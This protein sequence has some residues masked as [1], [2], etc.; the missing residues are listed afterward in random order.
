MRLLDSGWLAVRLAGCQASNGRLGRRGETSGQHAAA[1]GSSQPAGG[2]TRLAQGW[3]TRAGWMPL[4]ER[5]KWGLELGCGPVVTRRGV[6]SRE[7]WNAPQHLG[8]DPPR[9]PCAYGDSDL[10]TVHTVTSR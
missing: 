4:S 3:D 5:G 1:D 9:N 7:G 10:H 8:Q 6:G 2:R